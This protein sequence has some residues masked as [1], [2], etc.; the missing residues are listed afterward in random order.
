M[1]QQPIRSQENPYPLLDLATA[2]ALS[3]CNKAKALRGN[4]VLIIVERHL[5]IQ[6][7][8]ARLADGG[9]YPIDEEER[10]DYRYTVQIIKQIDSDNPM[11]GGLFY[12]ALDEDQ[13]HTLLSGENV[14]IPSHLKYW[15]PVQPIAW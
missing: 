10:S 7:R 15:E 1:T 14:F 13:L 6:Q 12:Q 11:Y 3:A 2:L 5:L 4:M 8:L 9:L